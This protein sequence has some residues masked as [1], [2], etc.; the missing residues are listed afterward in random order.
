MEV[1]IKPE[2]SILIQKS[3]VEFEEVQYWST[4]SESLKQPMKNA[5]CQLLLFKGGEHIISEF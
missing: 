2:E 5:S 3:G 1:G 4:S